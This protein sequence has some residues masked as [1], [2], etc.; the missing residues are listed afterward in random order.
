MADAAFPIERLKKR[1]DFLLCAQAPSCAKGAVVVQAR[2][3]P[4]GEPLVRTGFTATKRIGGAVDR[5]LAKRRMREAA[6][7]LVAQH[8]RAGYDYVFIAR[9]G[10]TKRP[11][12]RLLDDMKSALIRLAAERDGRDKDVTAPASPP[13]ND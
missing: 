12:P 10:V 7:L 3:R 1:A 5:N 11:W 8:G 6:R 13:Q 4:D 9:G 2:A